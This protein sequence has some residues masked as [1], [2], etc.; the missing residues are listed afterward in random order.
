MSNVKVSLLYSS[1]LILIDFNN[2]KACAVD[3]D[4][5][6]LQKKKRKREVWLVVFTDFH[7]INNLIV[8]KF[9]L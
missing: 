6:S 5:L 1:L 3:S 4:M 7:N 9:K 2:T 8:G